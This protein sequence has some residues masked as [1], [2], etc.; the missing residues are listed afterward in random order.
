MVKWMSE[1]WK[2]AVEIALAFWQTLGAMA[3]YLL[4]GFLVAGI[5][6]VWIAPETVERHL[7][8]RGFL[9]VLKS[10][11]LGVP[12]P[13]CSCGVI[14]VAASLRRSGA[15]KGAT[16]AFL[17]STPQTGVDSI[18]VTWS[19]L[20][21]IFAVVRPV[22][23]F[24][25]GL[26]C[27]VVVD[28]VDREPDFKTAAE[29]TSPASDADRCAVE[30]EAKRPAWLRALHHGFVV[31]PAD[32]ARPMLIGLAVAGL[33]SALVPDDFFAGAFGGGILGMLVMLALG[34]PIYVCATA[35]VPIAATLILKGISPGAAMVFLMTGP[36]TN[37]AAVAVIWKT[38]GRRTAIIYL[39]VLALSA[40]GF[41]TL[42]NFFGGQVIA[43][44][45]HGHHHAIFPPL[46][47]QAAAV[48]LL[49]V[50]GWALFRREPPAAVSEAA[51]GE[52]MIKLRISGMTCRHCGATVTRALRACPGVT[53]VAVDVPGGT[54]VV[55][56]SVPDRAILVKA[57]ADAG[58]SAEIAY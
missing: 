48:I 41:G 5:L 24:I 45:V 33:I 11:A 15:G 37:G 30:M 4:L 31:L 16:V 51:A 53:D 34:I 20:G 56:G 42:L 47:E 21:P 23:A 19:L 2:M 29:E 44:H 40:L 32:L 38:L 13:L 18:L 52:E 12:L 43:G 9:Q 35:S 1:I 22:A 58:Y 10:S 17:T 28:R 8:G 25:S 36:A 54:A 49:G 57:V 7:G 14:P 39:I 26:V 46:F 6:S 50:L 27:G 3:P 55:K